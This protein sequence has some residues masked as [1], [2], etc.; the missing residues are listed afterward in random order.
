LERPGRHARARGVRRRD[1]RAGQPA[2]GPGPGRAGGQRPARGQGRRGGEADALSVGQETG[3]LL[4]VP[5]AEPL[6]GPWRA[7][8]DAAAQTGVPAHVTLL[9]PFLP[10]DRIGPETL[11]GLTE[12]FASVAPFDFRLAETRRFPRIL[13]LAPR[14]A[15]RRAARGAVGGPACPPP[16][17]G[18]RMGG[19]IR[20]SHGA[21]DAG[22][23]WIP[24]PSGRIEATAGPI[25]PTPTLP[26]EGGRERLY[27]SPAAQRAAR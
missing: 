12:L 5:E 1:R 10:P 15:A 20:R 23:A 27:G 24:R 3:I 6:V 18:G 4:P 14:P 13:Y 8:Y 11:R 25:P 7:R 9:Y 17:G 26:R 22:V 16:R 21:R 2:G 19:Q